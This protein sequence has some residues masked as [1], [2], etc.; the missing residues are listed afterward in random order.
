MSTMIDW[1]L[2]HQSQLTEEKLKNL[3]GGTFHLP[4]GVRALT[5]LDYMASK[6]T[7]SNLSF[8]TGDMYVNI[9][10][11]N[12]TSN[13]SSQEIASI[14][15]TLGWSIAQGRNVQ[16]RSQLSRNSYGYRIF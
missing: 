9:T 12:V 6:S 11:P 2:L 4:D 15:S 8:Q 5:E 7:H 10:L 1:L 13:M 14:G 16:L 3:S